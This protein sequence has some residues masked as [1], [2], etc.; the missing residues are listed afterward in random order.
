MPEWLTNPY[1]YLDA[2]EE[3]FWWI[4]GVAIDGIWNYYVSKWLY[5]DALKELWLI[6]E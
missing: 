1:V 3:Q 5:K 6:Y 4:L 2:L